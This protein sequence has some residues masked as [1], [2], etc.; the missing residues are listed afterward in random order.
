MV[1]EC[2]RGFLFDLPAFCA[3]V[4][5]QPL[6]RA[7]TVL[8]DF[9]LPGMTLRDY[10]AVPGFMALFTGMSFAAVSRAGR[11][12]GDPPR[13]PFMFAG[14]CR[15]GKSRREHKNEKRENQ[16]DSFL[17]HGFSS[18]RSRILFFANHKHIVTTSFRRV[19]A[20]RVRFYRTRPGDSS[21]MI[22]IRLES[23]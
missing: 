2:R 12:F 7:G 20:G 1:A 10:G 14:G 6:A 21:T 4:F 19:L 16:A 23:F 15:H 3:G 13:T 8:Y 17:R 18:F 5:D 22:P 11:L 9:T